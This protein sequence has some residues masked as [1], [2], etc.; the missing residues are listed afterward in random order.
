M[1]E[2]NPPVFESRPPEETLGVVAFKASFL[3]YLTG[4]YHCTRDTCCFMGGAS[5]P[6]EGQSVALRAFRV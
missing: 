2:I 5:A 3:G 1:G 4:V 6:H